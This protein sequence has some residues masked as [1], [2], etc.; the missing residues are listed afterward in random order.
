MTPSGLGSSSRY[1]HVRRARHRFLRVH[2]GTQ[3]VGSR[4]M[5]TRITKGSSPFISGEAHTTPP[6]RS[7]ST[8]VSG[9]V[10]YPRFC[11]VVVVVPPQFYATV[12]LL[13]HLETWKV[14]CVGPFGIFAVSWVFLF[15]LSSHRFGVVHLIGLGG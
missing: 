2:V 4:I 3:K 13:C 11:A 15:L 8:H 1:A 7:M 14:E 10:Y 9:H 6:A 5:H 12:L